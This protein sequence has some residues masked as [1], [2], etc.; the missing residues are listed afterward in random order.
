MK[1]PLG[2]VR[3]IPTDGVSKVEFFGRE[4]LLML[5]D[6]RPEAVVNTCVHLGGPLRRDGDRLVCDWHQASYDLRGHRTG[7]PARPGS[8]LMILPTR[9][10][11]GVLH[12]VYG[13]DGDDV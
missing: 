9:V 4:V 3:D 10:E 6:G 2:K 1:V 11:D 5:V 8:R 7:G 13:N 12:Y